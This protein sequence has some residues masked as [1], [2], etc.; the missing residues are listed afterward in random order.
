MSLAARQPSISRRPDPRRRRPELVDPV[1]DGRW[2][3]FV[4]RA[5]GASV[6]HH[7]AWLELLRE[8]FG[9][10]VLACC[11]TD[12]AGT[13]QAGAP[14]ALVP[15]GRGGRRLVCVP[16]ATACGPLPSPQEDPVLA[17]E[18][19]LALDELRRRWGVPMELRGPI[20]AHPSAH[21]S[22]SVRTHHVALAQVDAAAVVSTGDGLCV[23][24]R[25]D[26]RGL[27]ELY[28]LRAADCRQL[29]RPAPRRRWLLG[30]AHLFDRGLGF[31]LLARDRSRTVGGALLTTFNGTVA[32]ECGAPAPVHAP[33]PAHESLLRAAARWGR[34]AGMR[35]FE[36]GRL[37][38]PGY[39]LERELGAGEQRLDYRELRDDAPPGQRER[40]TWAAPL[41][42]HSPLIVT[43]ALGEAV[44]PAGA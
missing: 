28:R 37:E 44:Y 26:A 17:H 30:F 15:D 5:P 35:T 19:V 38:V 10:P 2:A 40:L 29:G 39:R 27:A 9:C 1:E 33:S 34:D 32:Y 24:R 3:A 21:A 8:T 16:F 11:L 12:A 13:I 23:E 42:R 31:V 22:V 20:A 6:H 36:L 41:I 14:L 25:T 43:R 18:L 7:R 4:A